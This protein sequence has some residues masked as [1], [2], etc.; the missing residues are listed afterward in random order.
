MM[1]IC[2]EFSGFSFSSVL[3]IVNS[4]KVPRVPNRI[5]LFATSLGY[6]AAYRRSNRAMRVLR[7]SDRVVLGSVLKGRV[8]LDGQ[9]GCIQT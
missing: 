2:I 5:Y 1:G 9:I 7:T 4:F 8:V 6:V 3:A